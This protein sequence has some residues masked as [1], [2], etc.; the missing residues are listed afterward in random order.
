MVWG[1][2]E[3]WDLVSESFDYDVFLSHSSSNGEV[4]RAIAK[5]LKGDGVR[6]GFDEREV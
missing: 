3:R 6:V 1:R 2:K 5:G 4:F